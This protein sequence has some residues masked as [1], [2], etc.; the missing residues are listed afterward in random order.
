[1]SEQLMI[2]WRFMWRDLYV[3]RERLSSYIINSVIIRPLA[4]ILCLGYVLQKVAMELTP[5]MPRGAFFAGV[6]V[7][8]LFSL[9]VSINFDFLLDFEKDRYIDFQ[10]MLLSPSLLLIQKIFMGTVIL[11]GCALPFYPL[12]KLFLQD[13]F[14]T[15]LYGIAHA[16]LMLFFAC[17]LITALFYATASFIKK[18]DELTTMW[19]CFIYPL[20]ML[21]GSLIPWQVTVSYWP[22]LGYMLLLNP[23]IYVT[24]GFRQALFN[25]NRF[26]SLPLCMSVISL[27]ALFFMFLA[28]W[29]FRRKVDAV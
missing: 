29:F 17:W 23:F 27:Y 24:D 28:I 25:T 15:T 4:L 14:A 16:T 20:F 6:P 5:G 18:L 21:G 9:A 2:F 11:F 12:T 10:R 22:V 8:Y 3:H 1:M 19:R 26:F 7:M 13:L